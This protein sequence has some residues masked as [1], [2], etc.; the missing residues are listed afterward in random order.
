[1]S[2]TRYFDPKTVRPGDIFAHHFGNDQ[3][4]GVSIPIKTSTG[5]DLLDTYQVSSP[6]YK[7]DESGIDAAI[8]RINELAESEHDGYARRC[9][10]N[11]YHHNVLTQV[12][13]PR[14]DYT[15]ICNLNDY[16]G[17]YR[18]RE[19]HDYDDDDV[20]WHI[21][22]YWEQN[23]SWN[24]GRTMGTTLIRK[25][26]KPSD[27]KKFHAIVADIIDDAPIPYLHSA[28]QN[29]ERLTSIVDGMRDRG[30]L[31]ELLQVQYTWICERVRVLDECIAEWNRVSAPLNE[32]ER[33]LKAQLE[34]EMNEME[35]EDDN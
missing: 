5:W 24:L 21:P 20:I 7:R 10:Y 27:E 25:D 13:E 29:L 9:A 33:T 22:L 2:E 23:F 31:T 16:R 26:A 4:Y 14:K 11:Y 19:A 6:S 3:S 17:T 15:L 18:D 28:K 8:R 34:D 1:M 30:E 32:L 35:K 12:T